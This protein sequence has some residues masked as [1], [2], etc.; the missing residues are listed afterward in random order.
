MGI[1]ETWTMIAVVLHICGVGFFEGWPIIA[2]PWHWS[3]FCLFIWEW[4]ICG[5]IFLGY[6]LFKWIDYKIFL[7]KS[8]KE[9]E[10]K[11]WP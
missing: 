2:L 7:H 5:I 10:N 4:G 1:I 3:C 8:H 9:T 6:C 11:P